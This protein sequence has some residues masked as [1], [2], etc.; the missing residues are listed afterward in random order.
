MPLQNDV[1]QNGFKKTL[2]LRHYSSSSNL[3]DPFFLFYSFVF[4]L[5]FITFFDKPSIHLCLSLLVRALQAA[6]FCLSPSPEHEIS[7]ASDSLLMEREKVKKILFKIFTVIFARFARI[8]CQQVRSLHPLNPKKKLE[9]MVNICSWTRLFF[10]SN[11]HELQVF[12]VYVVKDV[13]N[14][15][16]GC[17][18]GKEWEEVRGK[19][20]TAT[21]AI[22]FLDF[23]L[24]RRLFAETPCQRV[25]STNP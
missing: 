3:I 21:V 19:C 8:G 1:M 5:H 23:I 22:L 16:S 11:T 12:D 14:F 13:K 9:K 10:Y 2:I 7:S 17:W 15:G 18:T 25:V 24:R 20:G 6:T 4:Y